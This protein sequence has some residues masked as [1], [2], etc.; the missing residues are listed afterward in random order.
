MTLN[1][2]LLEIKTELIH[3]PKKDISKRTHLYYT[4][5]Y[6]PYEKPHVEIIIFYNFFGNKVFLYWLYLIKIGYQFW[7]S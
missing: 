7:I 6:A 4:H 5:T 1:E 2:K 3:I